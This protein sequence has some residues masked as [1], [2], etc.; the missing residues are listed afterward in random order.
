MKS[1]LEGISADAVQ[2]REM[3]PTS[4]DAHYDFL[5]RCLQET[6]RHIESLWKIAGT[7]MVGKSMD[8]ANQNKTT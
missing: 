5:V 2:Y 8:E 4:K 3:R 7:V 1:I 6:H